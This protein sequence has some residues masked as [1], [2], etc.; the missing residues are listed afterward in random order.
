MEFFAAG[1]H[2]EYFFHAPFA[3]FGLFRGL[4]AID[5]RINIRLIQGG[6]KCFCG[7]VFFKQ[8]QEI[9]RRGSVARR[10]IGGLPSAIRPA[11]RA[12]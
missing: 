10:F 9:F 7:F 11:P 4:E 12:A 8:F 1:Q 2:F 5:N 3:G 6:E